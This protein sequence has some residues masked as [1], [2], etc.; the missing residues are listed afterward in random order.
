M[1]SIFIP[2]LT[3]PFRERVSTYSAPEWPALFAETAMSGTPSQSASPMA[4]REWP[5]C[6]VSEF[7][8][9]PPE[10]AAPFP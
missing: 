5:N 8:W 9:S 1:W 3:V 6:E 2:E 4:A 10:P 7:L